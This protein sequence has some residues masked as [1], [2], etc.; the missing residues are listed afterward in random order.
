VSVILVHCIVRLHRVA[1]GVQVASRWCLL[2]LEVATSSTAWWL[3]ALSKLARRLCEAPEKLCEG[4]YAH[5]RGSQ[6]ATLVE[7][8]IELP[9]LIVGSCSALWERSV[10]DTD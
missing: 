2:L 5:P 1:L 10:V 6:R 7:H 3:V 4:D 9:H 8:V